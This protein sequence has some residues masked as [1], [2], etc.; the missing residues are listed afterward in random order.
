MT[1][2]WKLL[3]TTVVVLVCGLGTLLSGC[4]G[5]Q[6]S[7]GTGPAAASPAAARTFDGILADVS[8]G[9]KLYDVREPDEYASGHFEKAENYPLGQLLAN[10]MPA[11]PK[12]TTI[13]VYCRSGVRSAQASGALQQAGY[14][15]VVDLGGLSAIEKIGGQLVTG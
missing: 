14:S 7:A 2:R 15:H 4:G 9:A 12:D 3:S 13:Y 8:S 10:T 11:V 6:G 1:R 5:D